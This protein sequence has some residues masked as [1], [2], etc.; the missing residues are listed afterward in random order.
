MA[1]TEFEFMYVKATKIQRE[2]LERL[3]I[4]N[5][6]GLETLLKISSEWL[7]RDIY[8]LGDLDRTEATRVIGK[9]KDWI[10]LEEIKRFENEK[11]K[12]R[13]GL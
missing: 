4:R 7:V 10:S 9:L 5:K 13:F 12:R 6:V 3:A 8:T 1:Y 11:F 2:E